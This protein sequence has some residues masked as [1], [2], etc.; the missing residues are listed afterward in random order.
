M[1]SWL[2]LKDH[3]KLPEAQ[4][5][6]S[7]TGIKLTTDGQCHLGGAI[8]TSHFCAQYAAEKLTKR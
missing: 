2:V 8:G 3:G 7:N 6:F 1:K 5:L 4:R